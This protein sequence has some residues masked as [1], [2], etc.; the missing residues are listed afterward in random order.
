MKAKNYKHSTPSQLQVH[1]P[2]ISL[3]SR[4]SN[5]RCKV[6]HPGQ[7]PKPTSHRW[8]T[9]GINWHGSGTRTLPIKPVTRQKQLNVPP[10]LFH[11]E[12]MITSA[13]KRPSWPKRTLQHGVVGLVIL[14]HLREAG[15]TSSS[16]LEEPGSLEY[17]AVKL[18]LG[19]L[20]NCF[21]WIS[22]ELQPL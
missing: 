4:W 14:F 7:P 22:P 21:T 18:D 13:C 19:K 8:F 17:G 5:I 20:Q 1:A 12:I 9:L 2:N 16:H 11:S 6:Q 15:R 3:A 10:V